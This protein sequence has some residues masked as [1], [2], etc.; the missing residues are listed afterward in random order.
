MPV[1]FFSY[2]D[3]L[4]IEACNE[5]D[6]PIDPRVQFNW[7]VR[8]EP[9]GWDAMS[10]FLIS[11]KEKSKMLILE[12]RQKVYLTD[13]H[14]INT[15]LGMEAD[16]RNWFFS[17]FVKLYKGEFEPFFFKVKTETFEGKG[18]SR[19]PQNKSLKLFSDSIVDINDFVFLINFIVYKD[20]CWGNEIDNHNFYHKTLCKY[21]SLI[22][23]YSINPYRSK[24][25]LKNIG[26]PMMLKNPIDIK[27]KHDLFSRT[28]AFDISL[29]E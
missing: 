16:D 22:D 20:I 26:Y 28:E 8:V 11:K 29:Y 10:S 15:I 18:M 3:H 12:G 23:H 14:I 9:Q 27:G 4:Y 2:I 7:F 25:F 1:S 24:P 5:F 13:I 6:I 17:K 21:I 19:Y